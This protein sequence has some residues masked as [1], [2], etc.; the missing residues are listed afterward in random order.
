MNPSSLKNLLS[1]DGEVYL[2]TNIFSVAESET[3]LLNLY[4]SI[5]W[6]QEKIRI[7]GKLI[8]QPRLSAWYGDDGKKYSYSGITLVAKRWTKQLLK[9]KDITQAITHSTFNSGLLNYYRD[10]KDS[11]GWH[12]DN[13]K[14]LGIQP[15][16]GSISL[17][18]KRTFKMHHIKDKNLKLHIKL[19]TGSCL[20]MRGDTQH[21]WK[22]SVPKDTRCLSPRLN[23]T[24]RYVH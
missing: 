24:F 14:E 9:I 2:F 10:G 4:E 3:L 8:K 18:A 13:E 16:I 21:F 5:D 11:M 1:Q 19:P 17:G 12:R 22:H 6:Q 7:Y 20:L 23:I 15:V